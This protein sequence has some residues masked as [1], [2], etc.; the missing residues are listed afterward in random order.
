[1]NNIHS[2][3]NMKRRLEFPKPQNSTVDSFL[4]HP[5]SM[6]YDRVT[7]RFIQNDSTIQM[8][9]YELMSPPRGRCCTESN[10]K[11][12]R[13]RKYFSSRMQDWMKNRGLRYE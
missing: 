12:H 13:H 7:K 11:M 8:D 9:Q 6:P 2:N 3:K 10:Y 5:L 1:M 4:W